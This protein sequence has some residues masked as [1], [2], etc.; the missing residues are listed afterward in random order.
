MSLAMLLAGFS[1]LDVVAMTVL[2]AAWIGA[3]VAIETPPGPRP[4]VTTMMYE[5]RMAWMVEYA[6]RGNR[7]FDSQIIGTLRQSTAFFASTAIIAIGGVLAFAGNTEA[8]ESTTGILAGGSP[9]IAT[10]A[11]LIGIALMLTAA[12][13]R[14]VWAN[15]VFGYCSVVMAATPMPDEPAAEAIARQAGRLN[16]QAA[17]NFNRGLRAVYFALAG[18]AWLA[19]PIPLIL[20]V[21]ATSAT[22]LRRE[23]ASHTH[24][25]LSG[26]HEA[27]LRPG[28]ERV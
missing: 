19:G 9:V 8:L 10:Q 27:L 28:G 11:K 5:M 12:F 13:L 2:V 21:A 18:L 4:S 23:F 26:K 15:R 25:I 14:F 17:L 20:A 1:I 6:R 16:I 22:L 3:G 24:A 7:I